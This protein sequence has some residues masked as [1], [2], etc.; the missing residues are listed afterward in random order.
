[1][2]TFLISKS[3]QKSAKA[4]DSKRLNKQVLEVAQ[5]LNAMYKPGAGWHNHPITKMWRNYH[6]ALAEYGLAM[7]RERLDRGMNPHK[8]TKIIKKHLRG[9]KIYPPW[10]GNRKFHLSHKSNLLRKDKKYYG[11]YFKNIPDSLPYVWM[12]K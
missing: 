8:S 12:V 1:M 6:G 5:I 9:Q 3:F 10:L 7:E 4:L 2:Q 11:R